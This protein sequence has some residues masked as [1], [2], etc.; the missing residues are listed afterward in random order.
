MYASKPRYLGQTQTEPTLDDT[1]ASNEA[2]ESPEVP[3]LSGLSDSTPL[4]P[5]GFHCPICIRTFERRGRL[6]AHLNSHS[7]NKPHV[8]GGKCGV[9]SW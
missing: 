4:T 1:W 7:R 9:M 3:L 6:D 8:C 5:Y 2:A